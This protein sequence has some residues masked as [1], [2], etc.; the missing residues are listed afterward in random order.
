MQSKGMQPTGLTYLAVAM[1]ATPLPPPPPPGA[2]EEEESWPYGDKQSLRQTRSSTRLP[3]VDQ[4]ETDAFLNIALC[5]RLWA[6]SS[7]QYTVYSIHY[8]RH[9]AALGVH[10]RQA[11]F[12]GDVGHSLRQHIGHPARP[13]HCRPAR[14][15]TPDTRSQIPSYCAVGREAKAT[16]AKV[17]DT[18]R[19]RPLC[20]G[21]AA[22]RRLLRRVH[23]ALAEAG[24]AEQ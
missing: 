9:S 18:A 10:V 13:L 15:Q 20:T 1:I 5:P 8:R 14:H 12:D 21:F 6:S 23:K 22:N 24:F 2:I 19:P 17:R 7:M 16:V 3:M 11:A 4:L